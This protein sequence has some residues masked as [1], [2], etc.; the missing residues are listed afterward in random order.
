MM[1]PLGRRLA[2]EVMIQGRWY[3]RSYLDE[4]LEEIARGYEMEKEK[5]AVQDGRE[6][7]APK[8]K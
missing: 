4:G 2:P 5:Q 7:E 1:S 6:I 8:I 3:P